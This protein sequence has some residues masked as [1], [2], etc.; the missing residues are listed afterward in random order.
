MK[1]TP[2]NPIPANQLLLSV[3]S[4]ASL[5]SC[6][7]PAPS[8][9]PVIPAPQGGI[10]HLHLHT[11]LLLLGGPGSN[12]S[13]PTAVPGTSCPSARLPAS[14][15]GAFPDA[16]IRSTHTWSLSPGAHKHFIGVPVKYFFSLLHSK[17]ILIC[18]FISQHHGLLEGKVR[19]TTLGKPSLRVDSCAVGH[20]V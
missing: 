5:A 6:P 10:A 12:C 4:A 3:V 9:G 8:Q 11:M 1:S 14:L 19:L 16:Q 15:C 17:E 18:P 13:C 2:L 20:Q 7:S